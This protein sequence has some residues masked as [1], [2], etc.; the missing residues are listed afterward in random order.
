[1]REYEKEIL[2]RHAPDD[3]ARKFLESFFSNSDLC[4]DFDPP[5]F[6]GEC[7]NTRFN[8]SYLM[9]EPMVIGKGLE[10]DTKIYHFMPLVRFV[11]MMETQ[12]LFFKR[13]T[14]WD[15]PWETPYR[16]L[17]LVK[18]K[19]NREKVNAEFMYGICWTRETS[20]DTGAMWRIY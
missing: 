7:C 14:E 6:N 12:R 15:D 5:L 16:R 10:P 3:K 20:Y 4:R 1:M 9:P 13:I 2:L 8:G 19:K 17:H 11:E 18:D